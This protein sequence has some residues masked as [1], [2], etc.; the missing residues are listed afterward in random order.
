MQFASF[1]HRERTGSDAGKRDR[2]SGKSE[3]V[4]AGPAHKEKQTA[5]GEEREE[6][7]D[8]EERN[9]ERKLETE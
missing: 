1:T 2:A 6:Q 8:E 4:I 7:R 3:S 5:D 9:E